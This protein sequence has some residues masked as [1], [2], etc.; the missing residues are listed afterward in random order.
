MRLQ[1]PL[2]FLSG[3]MTA[4]LRLWPGC[5]IA[6]LIGNYPP[7]ICCNGSSFIGFLVIMVQGC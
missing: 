1:R 2:F 3:V 4:P 5:S 6:F 7:L